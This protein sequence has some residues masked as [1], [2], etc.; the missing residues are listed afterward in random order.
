MPR[1]G[2]LPVNTHSQAMLTTAQAT[3]FALKN[4][5]AAADNNFVAPM[6][7]IEEIYQFLAEEIGVPKSKFHESTDIYG[8]FGMEGDDCF[9]FEEYFSERFGVNMDKF[10][11]YFHHGEEGIFSIGALLFK[12][13]YSRVPRIP[14]TPKVLQESAIQGS[15]TI[16]YPAHAIPKRRYDVAIN[17]ISILTLAALVLGI[18]LAKL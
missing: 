14:V 11:W 15:W 1:D 8:E 16:E 4:A 10:L 18:W 5:P 3:R 9:G 2:S 13:P 12:P 17:K 7:E 6:T